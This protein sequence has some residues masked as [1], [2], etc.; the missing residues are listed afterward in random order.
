MRRP[1]P[2]AG[3][4]DSSAAP[5]SRGRHDDA[6]KVRRA[7]MCSRRVMVVMMRSIL[8]EVGRRPSMYLIRNNSPGQI[9]DQRRECERTEQ[10]RYENGVRNKRWGY[11]ELDR[12]DC[13]YDCNRH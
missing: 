11:F 5:A 1:M 4:G 6:A 3:I 10:C 9:R 13:R 8:T 12:Q 2:C 7:F